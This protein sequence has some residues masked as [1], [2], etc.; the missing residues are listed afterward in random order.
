LLGREQ[1]TVEINT[2]GGESD[3]LAADFFVAKISTGDTAVASSPVR[4]LQ[5]RTKD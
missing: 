2:D 1:N 5:N 4:V 3:P